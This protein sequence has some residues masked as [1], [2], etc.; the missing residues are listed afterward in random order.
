MRTH[1]ENE[2][3]LGGRWGR[4]RNVREVREYYQAEHPPPSFEG[5]EFGVRDWS[6]GFGV[7]DLGCW[8]FG[9]RVRV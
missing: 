7:W 9:F 3:K 5:S 6:L 1:P 4:S 2:E 8:F